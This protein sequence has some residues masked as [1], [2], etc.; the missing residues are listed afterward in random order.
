MKSS[1][2]G[3]QAVLEGV[4]M[5]NK[6]RYA[7]AVRKPD[8]EIVVEVNEYKGLND[9]VKLF[10]LTIFR[11]MGA[12]VDSMIIGTKAL[13][14]SSSFYEEEEEKQ[15]PQ[16]KAKEAFFTTITMLLS[17]VLAIG[18][19]MILPY[20]L[21]QLLSKV[22]SS[23]FALIVIEAIIKVALF[24]GYVLII[25]QVKDI[26]RFF[27]YHGAEHKVINCIESGREL[28]IANV[29]KASKEHKR[30]GTS[31]MFYVILLSILFFMF[32][33]VETVWLRFILLILLVPVFA[34]VSY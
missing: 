23:H 1:G 9:K 8:Q 6:E 15:K 27:M 3:G 7:I 17:I 25:S 21:S 14:Y 22:I 16:S 18:F 29:K 20:Y 13:T 26:K 32:I 2:I 5:K 24:V 28:T 12:F 11:G 10:K 19:F 30:C 4:M 34:G 33:Q 31:F